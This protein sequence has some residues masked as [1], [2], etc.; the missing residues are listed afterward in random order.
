MVTSLGMNRIPIVILQFHCSSF[1]L[2][3]FG[4]ENNHKRTCLRLDPGLSNHSSGWK[5]QKGKHHKRYPPHPHK[6]YP[7]TPT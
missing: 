1:R 7:D 2:H 4:K 5:V 3:T 6:I